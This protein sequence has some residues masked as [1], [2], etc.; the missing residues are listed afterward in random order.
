[1]LLLTVPFGSSFGFCCYVEELNSSTVFGPFNVRQLSDRYARG[2]L[3]AV[4]K[5][6]SLFIRRNRDAART[7]ATVDEN[8]HNVERIGAYALPSEPSSPS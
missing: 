4:V 2:P 1:M 5:A 7:R 8:Q 6:T 3:P